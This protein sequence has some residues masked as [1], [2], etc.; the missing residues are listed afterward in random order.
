MYME[1]LS[2]HPPVTAFHMIGA[3][4][5]S[6]LP[7]PPHVIKVMSSV[8]TALASSCQALLYAGQDLPIQCSLPKSVLGAEYSWL[9]RTPFPVFH[10]TAC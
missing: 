9:A 10:R 5:A 6:L 1:Q 4:A 7:P 3:G 8:I 2:H